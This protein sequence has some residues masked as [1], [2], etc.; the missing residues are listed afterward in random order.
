MFGTAATQRGCG[1]Q[2]VFIRPSSSKAVVEGS[3]VAS[4]NWGAGGMTAVFQ[5]EMTSEAAA[6]AE[7]TEEAFIFS[8]RNMA[9]EGESKAHFA[10][11]NAHNHYCVKNPAS[12]PRGY[13]TRSCSRYSSD[14][15]PRSLLREAA[16]SAIQE[17]YRDD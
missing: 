8:S 16:R 6:V 9:N 12:Q 10:V 3:T 11:R 2:F 17:G 5:S 13:P 14:C 1:P 7:V 4:F 15:F